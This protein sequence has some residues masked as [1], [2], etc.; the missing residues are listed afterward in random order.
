[1]APMKWASLVVRCPCLVMCLS[2]CVPLFAT[3]H[4]FVPNVIFPAINL[5]YDQFTVD[6]HESTFN[7]NIM[8][9]LNSYSWSEG[10]TLEP[11]TD[12]SQKV[13]SHFNVFGT[14]EENKGSLRRFYSQL[15]GGT[16]SNLL[17]PRDGPEPEPPVM[18]EG[19]VGAKRRLLDATQRT[20]SAYDQLLVIYQ[21]RDKKN[22]LTAETIESIRAAELAIENMPGM[23]EYCLT[24]DGST[25]SRPLSAMNYFYPS[26][27]N[28]GLTFD[29]LGDEM[30]DITTTLDYLI[31]LGIYDFF[32]IYF[33]DVSRET[34]YMVTLF[35]FGLPRPGFAEYWTEYNTQKE[36]I[37]GYIDSVL[38]DLEEIAQLDAEIHVIFSGANHVSFNLNT[39]L[40]FREM[41]FWMLSFFFFL[42]CL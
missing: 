24:T 11:S 30:V 18:E 26:V 3:V 6:N 19:E 33:D 7:D 32:D 25:C 5:E 2:I 17:W 1:M 13:T 9:G 31:G 23:N 4:L 22:L 42:M 40:Q 12:S 41:Y 10:Y 14:S 21:R 34:E 15:M 27:V 39:F 28:G 29:G 37:R 16:Q 38:T 35:Q 8:L 20:V 36:Q